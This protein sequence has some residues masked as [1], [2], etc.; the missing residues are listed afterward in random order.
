MDISLINSAVTLVVGSVALI[1]YKLSKKHEMASAANIIVMDIRH[2]EG[3]VQSILEKG[4]VDIS[5]KDVLS[6]NNW[7]KYKHL[8]A[9]RFSQD[10]FSSFNRFFDSCV[11]MSDA[12]GRIRE[13]FYTGLN[14]K[15][16]I[17]QEKIYEVSNLNTPESQEKINI[18]VQDLN[19]GSVVFDPDEP[20]DRMMKNLQMMG[21]LSN[22][23]AF[24]KLK[25]ISGIKA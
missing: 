7:S 18:I 8:F 14:T 4:T 11:E 10:D 6:E 22:T 24:E 1:V 2:A 3:V 17:M 16:R 15:A 21:K 13:I 20:K 12:R 19:F 25:Q 5:T 23:T 9:R